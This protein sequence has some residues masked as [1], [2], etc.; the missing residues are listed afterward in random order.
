MIVEIVVEVVAF[1]GAHEWH[2]CGGSAAQVDV[3]SGRPVT[4]LGF[5]VLSRSL[6]SRLSRRACCIYCLLILSKYALD[7]ILV[8]HA[9]G[10]RM[11]GR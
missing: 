7:A 5:G 3:A 6:S 9:Q 11:G 4:P 1:L 2:R 8:R 10:P